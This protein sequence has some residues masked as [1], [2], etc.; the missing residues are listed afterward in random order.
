MKSKIVKSL[1]S[2]LNKRKDTQSIFLIILDSIKLLFLVVDLII[3]YI[4]SIFG[5]YAIKLFEIK[6]FCHFQ[7]NI[8]PYVFINF[9]IYFS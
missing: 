8:L 3:N 9:I 5:K 4:Y 1:S 2:S 7:D 6:Y